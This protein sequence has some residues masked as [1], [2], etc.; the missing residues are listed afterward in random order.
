MKQKLESVSLGDSFVKDIQNSNWS[1]FYKNERYSNKKNNVYEGSLSINDHGR[2]LEN[3]EMVTLESGK[4]STE[5]LYFIPEAWKINLSFLSNF[6]IPK[7]KIRFSDS[8]VIISKV[9][10]NTAKIVVKFLPSAAALFILDPFTNQSDADFLTSVECSYLF[11]DIACAEN[12]SV[13]V[14]ILE[15][16]PIVGDRLEIAIV[17]SSNAKSTLVLWTSQTLISILVKE[18]R[19]FFV[20]LNSLG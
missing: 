20:R 17:D 16:Y 12:L 8:P 13:L 5:C 4:D 9:Q 7:R 3:M 14:Q 2:N 6:M 11:K 19:P 10:S 18:V 15:I 1:N